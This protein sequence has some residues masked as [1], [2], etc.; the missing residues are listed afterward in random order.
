MVTAASHT[1]SYRCELLNQNMEVI[2]EIEP[3]MGENFP[4]ITNN[5]NRTVKRTIE[6]LVILP[7]D[8][9]AI[10][11]L[12]DRLKI[13]GTIDGVET[14]L[15][16]FMFI[17]QSGVRHTYGV[18][19]GE[20]MVDLGGVLDQP[21]G[22]PKGYRRGSA[23]DTILH[24]LAAE[25][26]IVSFALTPTGTLLNTSMN[27]GATVS[28]AAAMAEVAAVAGLYSPYFNNDGALA[29]MAPPSINDQATLRYSEG[30]NIVD[31]TIEETDDLLTAPNRWVVEV[32]GGE[33]S[34]AI[35]AAYDVPADAP[36][37]YANRGFYIVS[38][39]NDS[40]GLNS[41]DEAYQRVR[42]AALADNSTYSWAEFD[43]I[44][45]HGHDTF[46][47]VEYLGTNFREQEWRLPL[48]ASGVMHHSLRRH[49]E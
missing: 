34:Q 4:V 10:H 3:D 48:K 22:S 49:Y 25:V 46:D 13:Y 18:K 8:F 2:G 38:V 6:G 17:D 30:D 26:G 21:L 44:P 36:H 7:S 35:W 16:V 24:D 12:T 15:G 32:A 37:S 39:I 43:A 47:L 23:V 11:T 1:L 5:I 14:P 31:G 28:R 40:Q 42:A 19:M 9:A 45:D 33:E 20:S 41:Y 27:F 29:T